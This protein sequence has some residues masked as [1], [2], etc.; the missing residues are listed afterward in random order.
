MQ[1]FVTLARPVNSED[2]TARNKQKSVKKSFVSNFDNP[3]ESIKSNEIDKR[4]L[5]TQLYITPDE[6]G[7]A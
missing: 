7:K 3:S 6:E 4:C 5:H 2:T 1:L